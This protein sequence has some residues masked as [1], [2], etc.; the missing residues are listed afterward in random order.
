MDALRQL[1]ARIQS[2]AAT[3]P[4]AVWL[5]WRWW[6][7]NAMQ[8]GQSLIGYSNTIMISGGERTDHRR[9]VLAALRIKED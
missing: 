6:G 4:I 8:A 7:Y 3:E 2:F 5:L 9:N 1:G